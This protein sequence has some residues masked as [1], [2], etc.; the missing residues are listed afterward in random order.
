M[1][2]LPGVFNST[3]A[4]EGF[5]VLDAGWYLAKIVKSEIKPTSDKQGLRLNFQFKVLEGE[6]DG[7]IFFLGLNIKNKSEQAMAISKRQFDD[8]CEA[9]DIDE[10]ERSDPGFDTSSMHGIPL[11]VKLK[12]V[13]ATS[14]WPAKNEPIAFM[15]EGED[16]GEDG[17][18]SPFS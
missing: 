1:A 16:T 3:K 5:K 8:I 9:I 13:E 6:S 15:G 4:S 7:R 14:Q 17:E 2:Q 18:D 10:D 12:V 11:K